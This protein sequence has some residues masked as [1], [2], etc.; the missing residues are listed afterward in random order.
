ML[1]VEDVLTRSPFQE[2]EHSW[3]DYTEAANGIKR[4]AIHRHQTALL[5]SLSSRSM[6]MANRRDLTWFFGGWWT[7]IIL[8]F[9]ALLMM[10]WITP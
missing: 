6:G 9:Q 3:L 2:G 7:P 8:A 5:P 4:Y 1:V 10:V